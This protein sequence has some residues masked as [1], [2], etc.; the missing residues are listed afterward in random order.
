MI[1]H[2]AVKALLPADMP[3]SMYSLAEQCTDF[4]PSMRPDS[5]QTLDWMQDIFEHAPN[6]DTSSTSATAAYKRSQSIRLALSVLAAREGESTKQQPPS[7]EQFAGKSVPASNISMFSPQPVPPPA[8]KI[9]F[10][11]P[12]GVFKSLFHSAGGAAAAA[13]SN[14]IHDS[15]ALPPLSAPS[16]LSAA[17]VELYQPHIL[18]EEEY[19]L[20][21]AGSD[22]SEHNEEGD[23]VLKEGYLFKINE[24]GF[25]NWK[26]VLC[27]LTDTKLSWVSMADT[28]KRIV[29]TLKDTTIR[30]TRDKRFLL[31]QKVL[32]VP[33]NKALRA[34]SGEAKEVAETGGTRYRSGT[35]D[36][37]SIVHPTGGATAGSGLTAIAQSQSTSSSSVSGSYGASSAIGQMQ[38]SYSLLQKELAAQSVEEMESW[39]CAIQ[40]AISA[41]AG[42]QRLTDSPDALSI[43]TGAGAPGA[44]G[45]H[46]QP[47]PAPAPTASLED[48]VSVEQW[49]YTTGLP[50]EYC[51]LYHA[52]FEAKGY[53]SLGLIAKVGLQDSDLDYLEITVPSHRRVL[54]A[55]AR[56]HFSATL[57]LCVTSASKSDG[58]G[59]FVVR[60]ISRWH[61]HRSALHVPLTL[62]R[63]FDKM[64]RKTVQHDARIQNLPTLQSESSQTNKVVR[65]KV[66]LYLLQMATVLH[67]S[68][69]LVY[70]LKFLEL[71]PTS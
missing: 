54:S 32:A 6:D 64:L 31:S 71:G 12:S 62:L 41:A 11:S 69:Y 9:S 20:P 25:R 19:K 5:E 53:D 56:G 63:K 10:T 70:L 67:D 2:E 65:Y 47:P 60:V 28:S 46:S 18:R 35:P 38:H 4:D 23:T 21:S 43:H 44:A 33:S 15:Y 7:A 34:K 29:F 57:R 48:C 68:P 24:T 61:Y 30:R 45:G 39:I 13:S 49:L 42:Q 22:T 50:A 17:E 58:Y 40:E 37:I 66:E 1:N 26:Q 8:G 55:C 3:E 16:Q 14:N 59:G 51:E 36:S 27:T 52:A